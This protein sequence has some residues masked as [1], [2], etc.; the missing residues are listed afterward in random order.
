MNGRKEA[1]GIMWHG[2]ES[3]KGS[4]YLR[5]TP[6][7]EEEAGAGKHV[8]FDPAAQALQVWHMIDPERSTGGRICVQAGADAGPAVT[9]PVCTWR[10]TCSTKQWPVPRCG[11]ALATSTLRICPLKRRFGT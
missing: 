1:C 8:A 7:Q 2:L 5:A 6:A 10:C 3:L 4:G 9:S 11:E